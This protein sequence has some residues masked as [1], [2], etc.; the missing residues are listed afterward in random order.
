MSDRRLPQWM[1][2]ERKDEKTTQAQKRLYKKNII[3]DKLPYLEFS[4][5]VI[6]SHEKNDC[7]FLTEDL[8]SSLAPGSAVGFD[9]EWPPCFV[10]GKTKKV[11]L[12]QL[13]VSDE[14][15]YLFH[16]SSMSGFPSG[17][18]VLLQ[19][20]N[21]RKVG[22][23]IK[24]DMW[25]LLSDFDIKLNNFVELTD[26]AN[27]KLR[28]V[29]NWSLDGLLKHLFTKQLK[30]DK[31]VRCSQWNDFGLTE[32]QKIYAA[33]DAYAG[34]II[35]NKLKNMTLSSSSSQSGVKQK[36]LH[37]ASE[38]EELAGYVPEG[39]CNVNGL[40]EFVEDMTI[41]LRSLRHS[42]MV[43]DH[44][45]C[46]S[47]VVCFG[48]ETQNSSDKKTLMP[49]GHHKTAAN[50]Q[51]SSQTEDADHSNTNLTVSGGVSDPVKEAGKSTD[52]N[53][54][55]SEC[56]MSLDITA[57]ELQMLEMQARQEDL[58][59]QSTLG[60][61][62]Q[63]ALNNSSDL[64]FVIESDEEL[65][66]EMLQ[67]LEE[68]E[69]SSS[70]GQKLQDGRS[71]LV[72][73]EEDDE[74][75]EE[76]AEEE[77]DP[78][79]PEP[80]SEQIKCLKKYFGHSSFK[81]VQWKVI[82]SVLNERRDNLVV[83]A[84]GYG[85][86]LCFQFPPVYCGGVSVVISPLI[87]LMEDQVLQ[88]RMSNIPACFLGSAQNEN[89][90]SDVKKGHYRVVY[91]TPEFCTGSMWLLEQLNN[92]IGLSLLAIDEA[93]CI[94][95]WG[96]DFRSA[97]RKLSS[98]KRTLGDVPILA[99]TATASPS[100]REDI[101]KCL[102]LINPVVTCTS[103]DRPNI[104]LDVHCK[105]GDVQQDLKQ[106]LVKKG[107]VGEEYEFEGPTI[108]Y[109]PSRREAE[110]VSA[111][112]YKLNISCGV[113]HAGLGIKQRRET[114]HRFMR[115]EIQCMVA[116]V[117]FGMGINKADIR[118]VIHYGAPKEMESYYQEIG[119]AGRD[120]LP[121]ACHVLWA[122]RDMVLNRFLF[123][124]LKSN[125]FRG[126][127]MKM[128]AKMEKY[129]KSQR[130]RR[131]LILSHFED[132]QLRKVTSGIM[133]TSNC[134]DNCRSGAVLS[135]SREHSE[136]ALQDFGKEA[137]Q[138]MS[139]VSALDEKFGTT[140]PILF[141]RGSSSQR[142]PDIY[143]KHSLFGTGR[144]MSETWWK[145][146]AQKLIDEEYL[147]NSTGYKSFATLCKLTSKGKKWLSNAKCEMQRTLFLQPDDDLTARIPLPSAL[148]LF[149]ILTLI[150]CCRV[151]PQLSSGS[152]A[153]ETSVVSPR[154]LELQKQLY[155][156]LIT[157]RQKLASEKD[158]PP[159]ILATNKV[160]LDMARI[161]PRTVG[162][163][164]QVEGV[165][166]A[167][168]RMLEPLLQIV[169][170][171]CQAHDLQA[172]VTSSSISLRAEGAGLVAPSVSLT[173]SVAVTYRL[174][175]NEEKSL[176]QVCDQRSL[177]LAVVESHLLQAAR[178]GYPLDKERAGLS[179]PDRATIT[180]I[181]AS[182]PINS[183]LN[184]MK[185]IRA[186]VPED[187]SSFLIQLTVTELQKTGVPTPSS[188]PA[189]R[190]PEAAPPA[191]KEEALKWIEPEEK[192]LR[193]RKELS[194]SKKSPAKFP[195]ELPMS[196]DEFFVEIS[197]P[198]ES[199][200]HSL[201]AV[202]APK[203]SHTEAMALASWNRS[204]LDQDTEDLFSDS[205]PQEFGSEAGAVPCTSD[206]VSAPR[207]SHNKG[208]KSTSGHQSQLD[209]NSKELDS[210]TSPKA[211][212]K[213]AKR[214]LPEWS[215]AS[216]PLSS[217][218]GS[219]QTKKKKGLFE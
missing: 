196:D 138:L 131:K 28:C 63:E 205:P 135:Y 149:H 156:K 72:E 186:M 60:F 88:L 29:E 91:M 128:M 199:G 42:L 67:C 104:F 68:L 9:M 87:A 154:E 10:K 66:H 118:K 193:A 90:L 62:D 165:S 183:D 92:S 160:L 168:S 105:S 150:F 64:S 152:L 122:S 126:Y 11:A 151:Q 137:Y 197:M 172:K 108:V 147:K 177:P 58:V 16:I 163:L 189:S 76:E 44:K 188:P 37:M 96:H 98:L 113:Y 200:P 74:G 212:K 17:L 157:G 34:L 51:E 13:C 178:A 59:E 140:V 185:A 114:Q 73:D 94:S 213:L 171:F 57:Y 23:G 89:I 215:S 184:N 56:I 170:E 1:S 69:K 167:K 206:P 141:L 144:S 124:K 175:Q 191:V 115:D 132:K 159:A 218:A 180:R 217:A 179:A 99:L 146:L 202:S 18:K 142:L 47:E 36:L 173:D 187:I 61:Q 50:V 119:R 166:E 109:C 198:E 174:F 41:K 15:C 103:F 38:L 52:C 70:Q 46:T 100:V 155:G 77:L 210:E 139:A 181:I 8:R 162:S 134:C 48:E 102:K 82:Y 3:E 117:A 93:H 110:R 219:K 19:D 169:A 214:K 12:I 26:L 2:E 207:T 136:P 129:L 121:C 54:N 84:T 85:K 112:L 24:G 216:V 22:V 123:N 125:R 164:R 201:A 107:S 49:H 75:I 14:K 111:E 32:D 97:Y 143:H 4:G 27:E 53:T 33:T 95:E 86:S 148:K 5:T 195:A 127:K 71:R 80:N 35:Y 45:E 81:P 106:F 65:D 192:P 55:L 158:I 7:S 176:R 43:Y 116:T 120:G 182:H 40:A 208:M 130:C 101:V 153:K 194:S 209:H 25:K 31:D 78:S 20:E 190:G 204:H 203:A 21:I 83:M 39:E 161:R 79:V 30:K 6:Y 133:G 145:V 211:T